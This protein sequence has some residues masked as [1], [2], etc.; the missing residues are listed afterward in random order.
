MAKKFFIKISEEKKKGQN[1]DL[2]EVK[3]RL[4]KNTKDLVMIIQFEE[5]V[6]EFQFAL[7]LDS[8]S[9]EFNHK[10]YELKR[11]QVYSPIANLFVMNEKWSQSFF[12]EV[13]E[14]YEN[15]LQL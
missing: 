11:S 9:N 3:D 12:S 5:S 15:V 10:I 13:T 1:I 4:A 14:L 6:A 7:K 2:I 8:V